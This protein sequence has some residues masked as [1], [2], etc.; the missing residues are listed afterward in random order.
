MVDHPLQVW[1]LLTRLGEAQILLPAAALALL[2]LL[3]DAPG[4]RLALWWVGLGSAAVLATTATKLAFIG[5]GVGSAALDFTGISGHAMFAAAIYPLLFGALAPSVTRWLAPA[6]RVSPTP[7]WISVGLGATLALAIGVSRVVV[8]AHS[9]SEVVAGLA[10]GAAVCAVALWR[11]H[12][13]QRVLTPWVPALALAWLALTP[14]LAS[15][16]RTHP[17][18]TRLALALSGHDS[19]YTRAELHTGLRAREAREARGG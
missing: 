14:G 18:V 8:H 12:P 9:A 17:M 5:W 7:V 15:A 11:S 4:R 10:L 1:H 19:P 13:P 6:R 3:R 2:A 16:S